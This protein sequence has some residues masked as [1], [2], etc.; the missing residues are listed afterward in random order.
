MWSLPR[1]L[2][3]ERDSLLCWTC[4][5]CPAAPLLEQET[6]LVLEEEEEVETL[7]SLEEVE[8]SLAWPE[9]SLVC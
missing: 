2:R 8:A 4:T 5:L 7:L 9:F 3:E 6:Q 1:Y